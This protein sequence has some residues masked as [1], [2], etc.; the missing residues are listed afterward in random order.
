MSSNKVHFQQ[1][2]GTFILYITFYFNEISSLFLF[3][4]LF[5][6]T[7]LL[8]KRS[9]PEPVKLER[10]GSRYGLSL[11]LNTT[12]SDYYFS[13]G[14]HVGFYVNIFTSSDFLDIMNGGATQMI[15]DTNRRAYFKLI[16][17]TVRSTS[18]IEQYT[19][20]QRGCLFKHELPDQ[21]AGHYSFVDCLLKCKLRRIIGICH[22]MPF[23]LPN[24]FP[25]DTKTTIK[26]T[27]AHNECLHKWK[28]NAFYN[29]FFTLKMYI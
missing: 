17:T 22:C 13:T 15:V 4:C 19:P 6:S 20:V 9:A 11:V 12:I 21:Y 7:L 24:N 23:F 8:I 5:C 10:V 28:R 2:F 26:C 25:D 27:L 3:L 18:D 29:V 1:S 14:D 16:P